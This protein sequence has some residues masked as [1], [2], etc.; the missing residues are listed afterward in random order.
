MLHMPFSVL[1][2]FNLFTVLSAQ[3]PSSCFL[4]PHPPVCPST[5]ILRPPFFPCHPPSRRINCKSIWSLHACFLFTL[6]GDARS[7]APDSITSICLV[8]PLFALWGVFS[9]SNFS[10]PCPAPHTSLRACI[11]ECVWECWCS[12]GLW[13]CPQFVHTFFNSICT[14]ASVLMCFAALLLSSGICL[15]SWVVC[16][17]NEHCTQVVF[18]KSLLQ[19]RMRQKHPCIPVFFINKHLREI[20]VFLWGFFFFGENQR[21]KRVPSKKQGE[22]LWQTQSCSDST[23]SCQR[24]LY[25]VLP[26]WNIAFSP[27]SVEPGIR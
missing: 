23:K 11:Y 19:K 22:K 5:L 20:A 16:V 1:P 2:L 21:G 15:Q 3:F 10:Q 13:I 12:S 26:F 18:T 7:A 4:P 25:T 6:S 27:A 8:R 17:W 14:H 24:F 9:N